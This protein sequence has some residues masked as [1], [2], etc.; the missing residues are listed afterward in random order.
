M[1]PHAERWDAEKE[2]PLETLRKAAELGFG[3]MYVRDDV[4]GTALTR[5]DAAIIVEALSTACVSTTAYL[6]VHNMTAWVLDCFGSEALRQQ[7][8]PDMCSMQQLGS[9]CLTEPGSG[10][11]AAS[12]MTR[13][14]L[15][16]DEYVLNGTKAFISGGGAS[17]VYFV[18]ARSDPQD[19]SARG[20]TCFLVPKGAPGLSFGAPEHKLGWNSQPTCS[21][22]MEDCRIPAANVVGK[23]GQGF[24]IAMKALNGGRVNIAANALGG[25]QTCLNRATSYVLE[26]KQFGKPL[27]AQQSVQFKLADMTTKLHAARG[28]VQSAAAMLD[29]E[30]PSATMHCAMAKQ[31]STDASFEICDEALQLHGGYGYLRDYQIERFVR[32]V[33]VHRILEGTNE[34]MRMIISRNVL[35]ES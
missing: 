7:Y 1:A 13:A 21:V 3:G 35:K 25:A 17:D 11:D 8:L 26:R 4:G 29:A 19:K 9:Y 6:T 34:I 30:H 31:F 33:R 24:Q 5:Q 16:G 15:K 27:A 32:D 20:I 23:L 28:M 10:S 18:M 12:L 22:I 2:F 14:E